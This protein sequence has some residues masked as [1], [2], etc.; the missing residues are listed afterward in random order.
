MNLREE[1]RSMDLER[2][3][4]VPIFFFLLGCSA[5]NAYSNAG[6]LSLND[7][8]RILFVTHAVLMVCFYLL[9]I[10]LFFLRSTPKANSHRLMPKILAYVGTFMPFSLIF[11][12]ITEVNVA[13]TLLSTC[14]MTVGM[15]FSL[16]S[17]K[18]L[19]KSFGITPQART[20]V[21][22]GPYRFIR[23]PLY[24]GELIALGGAILT[25]FSA[26]RLCIYLVWIAIQSYRAIQE[27][28]LLEQTIADYSAY[29][30]QTR[31]FIPGLL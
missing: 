5:L 28:I 1:L 16:Y 25:G 26:Q 17:L 13:S 14:I 29:K 22:E 9:I 27:E 30:A 10:V 15:L 12:K 6:K 2:L 19:G 18:T 20:L 23:H 4:L 7:L 3:I 31:R 21:Q 24:V 11:T 8:T